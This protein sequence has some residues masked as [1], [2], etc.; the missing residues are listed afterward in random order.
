M[1]SWTELYRADQF[2]VFQNRMFDS[3]EEAIA[4]PKGDILLAQSHLTGL[5]SNILFQPELLVYDENYQNE[6]AVS[7]RF[8]SHLDEV[9]K[10]ITPHFLGRDVI[11][12]GCGKG[13]FL[14][15]LRAAGYKVTGLDPT[16]EGDDESVIRK[17][18]G[19]ELG[20]F[21]EGIILRHVL[22]HIQD[23]VAFLGLIRESNAGRG[24]IYI[25]VPCFDWICTHRAWFDIFY[26]HVNYFRLDDFYSMFGTVYSAGRVFG[27]Q[28]LYVIAD[29]ATL[30]KPHFS[31]TPFD[32]PN[33]FLG[34]L[35]RLSQCNA[36]TMGMQKTVNSRRDETTIVWG[37]ASKGVI[38]S[39]L[40]Q[41]AGARIDKIV[42]INPGK[43]GRYIPATGLRVATPESIMESCNSSSMIYVMNS[44]YLAEIRDLT[45]NQFRYVAIDDIQFSE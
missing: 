35:K 26:E 6:Q 43:Q 40:L 45:N 28:Y 17:F 14:Q 23:P 27:G 5:I 31:G 38:F 32:F 42:D 7:G 3:A 25:E 19:P 34:S 21:G 44:N 12:V 29:L 11:E 2:P 30:R 36:Q 15:K 8:Q 16:Y 22:E 41:R 10:L 24:T 9:V 37:A 20:L 13:F 39:L 18:Y 1:T 4:C 33:D